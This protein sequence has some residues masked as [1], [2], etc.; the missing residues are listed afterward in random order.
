[1]TSF[2]IYLAAAG[3]LV[4]LGVLA[5][6]VGG[7]GTGKITPRGQNKLMRLRIVAQFV[8]VVIVLLAVWAMRGS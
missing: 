4:T 5:F 1:M 8:T 7:F 2:L 6:G 3:C